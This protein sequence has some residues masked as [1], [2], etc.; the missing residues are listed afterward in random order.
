VYDLHGHEPL[1]RNFASAAMLAQLKT[2]LVWLRDQVLGAM[3]RGDERG[4]IHQANLI[5]PGLLN[6]QPDVYQRYLIIR[7]HVIDRLYHQNVGYWQSNLEG[8][9]H[10]TRADP[11]ELLV[12]YLGVSE[13]TPVSKSAMR[14]VP[15]SNGCSQPKKPAPK[16]LEPIPNLRL[17]PVR[18]K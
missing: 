6:D 4:V 14:L 7:E 1:T 18:F 13:S 12:D 8:L 10:L 3:R 11:A 16:W 2:D 9:E 17:S 15:A 5:P